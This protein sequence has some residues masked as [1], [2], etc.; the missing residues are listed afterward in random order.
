M[1][2]TRQL[3]GVG[4]LLLSWS[5]D[6]TPAVGPA[7]TSSAFTSSAHQEISW[8]PVLFPA[9]LL[10]TESLTGLELV[11]PARL[12]ASLPDNK[13]QRVCLSLPPPRSWNF[14]CAPTH[15]GVFRYI[16]KESN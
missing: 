8:S 16:L 6:Q 13:P 15:L 1:E 4:P 9:P 10:Q 11:E 7:G 5:K 14:K 2:I 3:T 12:H